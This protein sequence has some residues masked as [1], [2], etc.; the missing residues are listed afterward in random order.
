MLRQFAESATEEGMD[1]LE[2]GGGQ[3]AYL[4]TKPG[5]GTGECVADIVDGCFPGLRDFTHVPNQRI[6]RI[7]VMLGAP[8]RRIPRYRDNLLV[9]ARAR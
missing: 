6:D 8:L 3:L 1:I 5:I 9:V 7:L 4:C 2:A